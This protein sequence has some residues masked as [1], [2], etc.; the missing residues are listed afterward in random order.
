MDIVFKNFL[1]DIEIVVF[2]LP[3]YLTEGRV[4]HIFLTKDV[5]QY[6]RSEDA[7]LYR[8]AHFFK[9]IRSLV[10]VFVLAADT[11]RLID[12]LLVALGIA[13]DY[14]VVT[15]LYF[16]VLCAEAFAFP[17]NK[18]LFKWVHEHILIGHVLAYLAVVNPLYADFRAR[19]TSLEFRHFLLHN[20]S[21]SVRCRCRGFLSILLCLNFRI[22]EVGLLRLSVLSGTAVHIVPMSGIVFR[23]APELFSAPTLRRQQR[24]V[25]FCNE[26]RYLL[27]KRF[28]YLS[29]CRVYQ[30]LLVRTQRIHPLLLFIP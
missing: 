6:L 30:F 28:G 27:F 16:T 7:G 26:L 11:G 22:H 23:A 19:M 8:T 2:Q 5:G 15:L 10:L 1:G 14:P 3:H 4:V 29:N 12:M 21:F 18:V 25:A 13:D 17:K 24:R 20:H 9:Y